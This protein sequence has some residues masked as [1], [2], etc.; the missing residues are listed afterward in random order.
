MLKV[1]FVEY[2]VEYFIE[3]KIL[4]TKKKCYFGKRMSWKNPVKSTTYDSAGFCDSGDGGIF[5][6]G[7]GTVGIWRKKKGKQMLL[8]KEWSVYDSLCGFE[9]FALDNDLFVDAETTTERI[10]QIW[11]ESSKRTM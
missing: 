3:K 2:F 8:V 10:R 5:T 1:Y 4:F 11:E 6:G 9:K 7:R